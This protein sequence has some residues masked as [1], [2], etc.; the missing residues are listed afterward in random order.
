MCCI[1][2]INA[3]NNVTSK[4]RDEDFKKFNERE[5]QMVLMKSQYR[6]M[7]LRLDSYKKTQA[8]AEEALG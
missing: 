5:E 4:H 1:V 6:Q 7:E 3:R 8:E 2:A